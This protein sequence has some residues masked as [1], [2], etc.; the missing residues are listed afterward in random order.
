MATWAMLKTEK[1]HNQARQ[2]RFGSYKRLSDNATKP[3]ARD[4]KMFHVGEVSQPVVVPRSNGAMVTRLEAGK[5]H[6]LNEDI[7]RMGK[8]KRVASRATGGNGT[9]IAMGLK[10]DQFS[11]ETELLV[12]V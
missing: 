5:A 8:G 12:M 7:G 2:A 6:G 10:A 11:Y 3:V 9:R 1:M 4:G